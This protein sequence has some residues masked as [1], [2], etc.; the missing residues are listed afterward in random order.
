MWKAMLV[1]SKCVRS[2]T[3]QTLHILSNNHYDDTEKKKSILQS[4]QETVNT[5][6][7]F[8]AQFQTI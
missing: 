7:L 3:Q 6:V 5:D 2:S 8:T 1:K 4:S